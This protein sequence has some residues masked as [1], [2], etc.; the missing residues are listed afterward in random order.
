MQDISNQTFEGERALFTKQDLSL[1]KC[2]FQNGESPLKQGTN[3]HVSDST[4]KWKYPIWY[5]KNILICNCRFELM[6]RAGIWYTENIQVQS[7]LFLCPKTFRRCHGLTLENVTFEDGEETLWA[8]ENITIKNMKS[9][10]PYLLMNSNHIRIDGLKLD[11]NYP[12]D[13]C[14]DVEI[15][16][17]V[18]N[19]KDAFWNCKNVTIYDSTIIGEYFGWNS[20]NITLIHCNVQSLQGF[21][22]M[23]NV[24]LVHCKLINTTLAF[25]YSTIDAQIDSTIDSVKNPISGVLKAKGI[26][27]LIME[28]DRIDPKKTKIILEG[29][30]H[31]KTL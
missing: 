17:S 26:N 12:F 7:S 31:D 16:N 2:I 13:G 14:S 1:S 22:Y 20:E 10:G 11:G 30:F 23:K 18:L 25:E 4:F 15:H 9:K 29:D 3:L 19:S 8:C 28:K 27:Q 21:C 6:A 5:G 24:K